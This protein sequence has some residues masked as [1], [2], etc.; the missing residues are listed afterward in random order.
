M[1]KCAFVLMPCQDRWNDEHGM[2]GMLSRKIDKNNMKIGKLNCVYCIIYQEYILRNK[3]EN[4]ENILILSIPFHAIIIR[5]M[6]FFPFEHAIR[7]LY[8][9]QLQITRSKLM[10]NSIMKIFHINRKTNFHIIILNF[11]SSESQTVWKR[12]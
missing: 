10:D 9:Q 8:T 4:K 7:T 6:Y 5:N 11:H 1:R 3:L 2:L 12:F